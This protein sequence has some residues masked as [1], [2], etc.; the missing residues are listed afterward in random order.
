MYTQPRAGP[1]H[2]TT[3]LGTHFSP[4]LMFM[5][6]LY[7]LAATPYT[8]FLIQ[9]LALAAPSWYIYK[10]ALQAKL[11]P[12]TALIFALLYLAY[13][14]TLWSNWYDFHLEAFVPIFLSA[15]YY[16]YQKNDNIRMTASLILL[17]LTFERAI[18]LVLAFALYAVVREPLTENREDPP[19]TN[20]RKILLLAIVLIAALYFIQSERIMYQVWPNRAAIEPTK[21]FGRL[22]YENLLLKVSFITLLTASLA[23]LPLFSPLELGIASPYILLAMTSDYTPYFTIPWQYPAIISIPFFLAAIQA[24]KR[25][26]APRLD[27]KLAASGITLFLLFAPA[28]PLM[29]QFS[30]SWAIPIP[31]NE[32]IQKHAALDKIPPEATI[33]AQENIFPNIAERKTAYTLWPTDT[34]PP[35]YI[36]VDVQ[37]YYFYTEP[38]GNTT[39]DQLLSMLQK[40]P[41]GIETRVNGFFILKHGYNGTTTTV[42]PLK[43]GIDLADARN[44]IVS[45]EDYFRETRFFVPDSVTVEDGHITIRNGTRGSVWW[46]PFL[47]LPPGRYRVTITLVAEDPGTLNLLTVQAY[48]YKQTTYSEVTITGDLLNGEKP[49]TLAW[50]FT[51]TEWAPSLE[52]VGTSHGWTEIHVHDLTLEAIR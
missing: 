18:F 2:P 28:T 20:R 22:T 9:S 15:A 4:L 41:Y 26:T 16:H 45:Q 27:L 42:T 14:G 13:P 24:A 23:F 52:V 3:F 29:T 6:E 25:D 7:R 21:M 17:M 10:I 39:R 36:V 31:D 48:L 51:L 34:P 5:I 49:T 11:K 35:D 32:T 33:L 19:P 8:L 40:E 46:G 12:R 43:T 30:A 47:T 38:V 50:E 44:P 1:F 37:S